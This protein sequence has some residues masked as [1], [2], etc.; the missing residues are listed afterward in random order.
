M[1]QYL[2][3]ILLLLACPVGMALMMWYM[4]RYQ[5]KNVRQAQPRP[6]PTVPTGHD[7]NA[8]EVTHLQAEIDQLKA[9][10]RDSAGRPASPGDRPPQ[11]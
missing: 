8:V 4:G 10:Q 6:R 9:A 3:L 2:P 5:R 11:A 1:P 7:T